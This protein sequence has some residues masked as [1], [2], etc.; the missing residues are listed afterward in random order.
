MRWPLA[1]FALL[2]VSL[3]ALQSLSGGK[4]SPW[5]RAAES[6]RHIFIPF[7]AVAVLMIAF[8]RMIPGGPYIGWLMLLSQIAHVLACQGNVPKVERG[9][10]WASLILVSYLWVMQLPLLDRA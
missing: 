8:S 4:N 9:A 2:L 3:H 5:S 1:L 6:A 10:H 7:A